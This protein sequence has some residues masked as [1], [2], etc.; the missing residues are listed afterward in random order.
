LLETGAGLDVEGNDQAGVHIRDRARGDL[1]AA[2]RIANATKK[3][4]RC[5]SE[6]HQR[7]ACQP[8]LRRKTL[9]C[10]FNM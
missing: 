5:L 10:R 2:L 8:T 9:P 6:C 3:P 7:L 1:L 4:P